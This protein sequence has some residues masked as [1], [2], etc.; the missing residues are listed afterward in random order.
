MATTTHGIRL[1][2]PQMAA[3]RALSDRRTLV[4]CFG[5]GVG[6]SHWMRLAWWRLVSEWEHKPRLNSLKRLKGVRIIVLMPT[7]KQGKDV[8][9]SGILD[10]LSSPEWAHLRGKVNQQTLDITFPGGSW[11]K[12]FPGSDYNS[13]RALGMRADV[14]AFDEADDIDPEV[15]NTVAL[16]WLSEPW[17]L[18]I[19]LV[20]GTPR[21]GRYG[22]LY[23]SWRASQN[24]AA[25]R[26]GQEPLDELSDADR[27]VLASYHGFHAT[28][29]DAPETVSAETVA[30]A[31]ATVPASTFKREWECDFDAGEGLVYAFFEDFHVRTPPDSAHWSEFWVGVDH[32]WA[33]P[34]VFL[35]C[36]VHG[37]GADATLWVLDEYYATETANNIWNAK[38]VEWTKRYG[39]SVGMP[40]PVFACDRSR[41]DRINDLVQAGVNARPAENAIEAGVARVAE[42]FAIRE[43][44]NRPEP[45][46][47]LYIHP[48]CAQLRRELQ[49]Y[50]RKRDPHDPERFL[51]AIEDRN[52][53]G[54]DALR[55]L[56]VERFGLPAIGKH[57]APGR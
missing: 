51:E 17:S 29:A 48:R 41:P 13:R 35:L 46:A 50:R 54:C 28:Y 9:L 53:H 55:Y 20:S 4:L 49:T 47:R 45:W 38:A 34:G 2:K 10:D 42:L 21:R 52:N 56:A 37:R 25:L 5:R 22:L 1:N 33:D 44:D 43:A 57:I 7:L 36:A 16:P 31:R 32:G 8:H 11:V 6:K 19:E 12:F 24:G 3:M 40:P 18:K 14:V 26:A 39:E 23:R 30:K 27:A 15:R